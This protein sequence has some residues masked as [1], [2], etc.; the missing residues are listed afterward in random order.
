MLGYALGRIQKALGSVDCGLVITIDALR[1]LSV[2][3]D[4]QDEDGLFEL[5][6]L[7]PR[8]ASCARAGRPELFRTHAGPVPTPCPQ[9]G[10]VAVLLLH[11]GPAAPYPFRPPAL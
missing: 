3:L 10:V 11:A 5:V 9:G 6:L 8:S 4:G 7:D 1:A 2:G